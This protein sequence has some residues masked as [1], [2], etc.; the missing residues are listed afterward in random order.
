MTCED[1]Q[2]R[3]TAFGLGELDPVEAEAAR[4]HVASCPDCASATLVDRQLTALLRGAAVPA[5][6]GLERRVLAALREEAG[7][8]RPTGPRRHRRAGLTRSL[9]GRRRHWLALGSGVG[10]AAAVVAAALLLV[11]APD[12]AAP[13]AAAWSA[14]RSERTIRVVAPT[15]AVVDR[16]TDVLGPAARTP[17]LSALGFHA[18][19]VGARQLA[20]HLAAVA[21]YRDAAGRRVVLIRWRG[22]LP[23]SGS[24]P[25]DEAHEVETATWGRTG[26]AWWRHDEVVWCLIGTVDRQTLDRVADSLYGES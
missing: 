2:D 13:L 9:R 10:L 18:R 8:P 24:A 20:G 14:Y 16:L 3:L 11:P 12:R 6:A 5:P 23:R 21:E 15:A 25:S 19:S 7:R 1:F 17:D 4:R 26:S 22:E